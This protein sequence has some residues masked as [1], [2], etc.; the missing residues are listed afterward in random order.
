[1]LNI[2]SELTEQ[3]LE[4]LAMGEGRKRG[5]APIAHIPTTGV[6]TRQHPLLLCYS[7]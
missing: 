1:M 6:R 4:E 3:L 7:S 2:H 5:N